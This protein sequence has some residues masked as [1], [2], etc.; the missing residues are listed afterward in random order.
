MSLIY[1]E[2][3]WHEPHPL[4]SPRLKIK[5]AEKHLDTIDSYIPKFEAVEPLGLGYQLN[6]EGTFY[7]GR[8]S[9]K[10]PPFL[11]FGV[12]IGEFA[13]Q[14]R[15]ALDNVIYA[16]SSPNFPGEPLSA[17]RGRA[18]RVPF[19][20][21]CRD[22][23]ADAIRSRIAFV[24]DD[25]K[26]QV[27]EAIDK[28][29]PYKLG[30]RAELHQ[31]AV[32]DELNIRDKHRIVNATTSNITIDSRSVPS[33]VEVIS[34]NANHGDIVVRVPGHLDPERDFQPHISFEIILQ[35]GRPAEG[36]R[37]AALRGIYD[38]VR[39]EVLPDFAGFFPAEP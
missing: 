25:I 1:P 28:H 22:Q 36:I 17:Q 24:A 5:W 16:L 18:E 30:D 13:Y 31:L 2:E 8:L 3:P 21:I 26:E 14:L 12:E 10:Y 33:G 15:S 11:D 37:L 32:L 39:E 29:Q 23:N 27:F 4:Q 38:Y 34:G 9:A 6:A 7:E 35:L 19:F 20:A